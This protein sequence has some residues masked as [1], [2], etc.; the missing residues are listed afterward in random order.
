M[1][2]EE[3]TQKVIGAGAL[4]ENRSYS[5]NDLC[6]RTSLSEHENCQNPISGKSGC[7]VSKVLD[8]SP[9]KKEGSHR[10]VTAALKRSAPGGT[11]G[12]Y[13]N[14]FYHSLPHHYKLPAFNA[15]GSNGQLK[16]NVDE[17]LND[18]SHKLALIVSWFKGFNSDQKNKLLSLLLND[19][20]QPQNHHVSLLMQDKL[21]FNCPPNCQ[22]FL[23][24]LPSALAYKI[25]SFLD[26][27]SLARCSLVCKYWHNLSNAQFLWQHLSMQPTWRLTQEGHLRQMSLVAER[28]KKISWKQVPVVVN[29]CWSA[30]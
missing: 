26:P 6:D 5:T 17:N 9:L 13:S 7:S 16:R 10:D 29:Y 25:L 18:F 23:L 11:P 3:P 28:D 4:Q 19:S 15:Q 27:V 1:H 8:R 2:I 20:E 22:D 12:C 14:R 24:W 21:H 30:Y